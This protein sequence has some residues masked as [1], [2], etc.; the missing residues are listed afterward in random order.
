MPLITRWGEFS[1]VRQLEIIDARCCCCRGVFTGAR[2][3]L[4]KVLQRNNAVIVCNSCMGAHGLQRRHTDAPT[5][6]EVSQLLRLTLARQ[7]GLCAITGENLQWG[8][9]CSPDHTIAVGGSKSGEKSPWDPD[10]LQ[11]VSIAANQLKGDLTM[12]QTTHLLSALRG[13]VNLVN[14]RIRFG[15]S[16]RTQSALLAAHARGRTKK[17]S[18]MGREG[19]AV[20]IDTQWIRDQWRSNPVCYWSGLPF[21]DDDLQGMTYTVSLDRL[22]DRIGYTREN[23][24]L[25]LSPFN[26]MRANGSNHKVGSGMTPDQTRDY[27]LAL[28]TGRWAQVQS[29]YPVYHYQPKIS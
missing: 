28:K 22:D 16:G 14:T 29:H 1:A 2:F 19:M 5:Q 4:R 3:H 25:C 12:G 23:T 20:G 7:W 11:V 18:S 6:S 21:P 17:R 24:V 9:N 15:S 13:E 26:R 27:I 10:N 8:H